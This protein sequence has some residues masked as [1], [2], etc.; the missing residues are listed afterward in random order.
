MPQVHELSRENDK[1][2]QLLNAVAEHMKLP[3][4]YMRQHAELTRQGHEFSA[5][6]I[7]A[8]SDAGMLLVENYLYW[9]SIADKSA[10]SLSL[11]SSSL[12]SMLYDVMHSLSKI[13]KAHGAQLELNITG[14][15]GQVTTHP[16][17]LE[18]ALTSLGLAY[19]EAAQDDAPVI[20]GVHK[21]RWG[22]VTGVY[23][24][25]ANVTAEMLKC[26][27][28]LSGQTHQPMPTVS[29]ASMSG[30]IIADALLDTLTSRLRIAKHKHMSGLATT[31]TPNPQ[32]MLL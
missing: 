24:K 18:V 12:S 25:S 15:Y 3:L 21:S 6:A 11:E 28:R 30:Y 7:E 31:L 1:S 8:A 16:K 29:H 10:D 20:F 26:G 9:Q 17:T 19:I 22:I 23:S 5:D 13:A 27:K 2:S 32:L 4:L 14:K